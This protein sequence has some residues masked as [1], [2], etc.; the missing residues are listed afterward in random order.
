M[1][2]SSSV[3]ERRRLL[4]HGVAAGIIGGVL[5]DAFLYFATILPAHG[6]LSSLYQ[7]IASNAV[8]NSAFG[9]P[10]AV[11]IGALIHFCISI[12]WGI[13]FSYAVMTRAD[14]LSHPY[15]AGVAFGFV[16]QIIMQIVL[17]VTGHFHKPTAPLFAGSFLAH[18]LFFGLPVALYFTTVVQH[19]RIAC[20][21]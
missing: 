20:N 10:N 21:R 2:S 19:Q 4:F 13:G 16:V 5:I 3:L 17:A 7:Y 15:V 14:I 18:T 8:G 1:V 11:W 12:A 6:S 9:N